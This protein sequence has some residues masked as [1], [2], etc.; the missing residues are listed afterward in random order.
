MIISGEISKIK[1]ISLILASSN[2][3]KEKICG[4]KMFSITTISCQTKTNYGRKRN[5]ISLSVSLFGNK[6]PRQKAKLRIWQLSQ[7]F[8]KNLGRGISLNFQYVCD[9][10]DIQGPIV[11]CKYALIKY[12]FV[13]LMIGCSQN[14]ENYKFREDNWCSASLTD[15][16]TVP[17]ILEMW[18][19]RGRWNLICFERFYQSCCLWMLW[20]WVTIIVLWFLM[21]GKLFFLYSQGTTRSQA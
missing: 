8:L 15:A 9:K 1:L 18:G 21:S 17:P 14:L 3:N 4:K 16:I 13:Y 19:D 6:S 20:V 10:S 2:I 5:L 12:N 11:N 7:R